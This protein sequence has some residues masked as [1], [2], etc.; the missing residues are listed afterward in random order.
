MPDLIAELFSKW[1]K[2]SPFLLSKKALLKAAWMLIPKFI[3]WKLWLERNN[4]LFKNVENPPS[5]IAIKAR[6]FLGETLDH[7][8]SLSNAHPLEDLE[9]TWLSAITSSSHISPL[10]R[11]PKLA[12]WE[13]RLEEVDFIKWRCSLGV[14]CLFFDGASKCNLGLRVGEE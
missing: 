2:S 5:K 8:L 4:R 9:F 11:Q 12:D 3:I 1:A 14:H 7:K 10:A 6:A 13:I